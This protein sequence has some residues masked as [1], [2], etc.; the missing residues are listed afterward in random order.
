MAEKTEWKTEVG[1]G[2]VVYKKEADGLYVLLT[3]PKGPNFGPPVGYWVFPKGLL[4]GQAEEAAAVREVR[5]E[6]G[7][8]AEIEWK[9]GTIRYFRKSKDYGNAIKIVT[10]F[11]M[12]YTSGN[13]ADHDN[14]M[15]DSQWF[16][17]EEALSKLKFPHDK[18]IFQKA[19]DRLAS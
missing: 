19:Y 4:D 2:G 7:V 18:E 14:E 12:K 15:A 11:L 1:A 8:N 3:M 17:L 10:Y 16:K 9:L 6:G 13:P 5:E